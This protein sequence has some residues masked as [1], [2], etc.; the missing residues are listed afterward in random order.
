MR[1]IG[2]VATLVWDRIE[3]PLAEPALREQWG[4]AV[5]SFSSLSAA[6]PE[7]WEVE[8]IVKIGADLWD[9]GRDLLTD[10]P[11]IRVGAGVVQVPEENNRVALRYLDADRRHELQTGGVP[12]WRWE[13]IEPLLDGLSALYVNFLSGVELDLD[14]MQRVRSRFDGPIHADLHS[15]FLSPASSR[16]RRPTPLARW[17]EWLGCFDAIQLNEDEMAL[18][19]PEETDREA[20]ER[21]LTGY[22]PGLVVATQGGRGVRY[23]V[24]AALPDDP[25]SWPE[26]PR[27][28]EVRTGELPAPGGRL[29]GDPT[30]CGDV[31][32]AAFITGMLG[33]MRLEDAIV[34][35]ERLAAAKILHPDTCGLRDRLAA[36][37]ACGMPV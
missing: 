18:L 5:Y 32:G 10:L 14:T 15:L 19:A 23:V 20:F 37:V 6:L 2:A 25:L 33:G 36:V 9:R 11:G 34:R 13:E 29:A 1:R 24:D 3:N 21:S 35:A 31:W 22:G 27:S 7:G 4:G 28:G 12:G 8:P 30:G 16:P 17:R 26:T